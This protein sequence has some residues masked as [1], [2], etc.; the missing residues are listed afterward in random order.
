M[1]AADYPSR[2]CREPVW[3][4]HGMAYSCELPDL[5]LGPCASLSSQASVKV[6]DAWEEAHP[7]V[8]GLS[9]PS[10]DIIVDEPRSH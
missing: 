1:K 10:Q 2:K 8:A 4:S 9:L 6:R 3:G 7:D 5:H